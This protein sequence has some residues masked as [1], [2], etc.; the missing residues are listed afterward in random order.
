MKGVLLKRGFMEGMGLRAC[1]GMRLQSSI[2]S[3]VHIKTTCVSIFYCSL[4]DT[5]GN[6][7]RNNHVFTAVVAASCIVSVPELLSSEDSLSLSGHLILDHI[8]CRL[9]LDYKNVRRTFPFG[10]DLCWHVI[11][12]SL[13]DLFF[14]LLQD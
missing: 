4:C 2:V 3:C 12:Q 13:K 9:T 1:R 7:V 5:V 6:R 10:V 8:S 11:S 14:V